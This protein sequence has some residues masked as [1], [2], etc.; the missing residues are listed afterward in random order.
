MGDDVYK[1]PLCV[2]TWDEQEVFSLGAEYETS[3]GFFITQYD[4]RDP[5]HSWLP[6]M[7]RGDEGPWLLPEML[8]V[9]TW[10]DNVRTR[11]SGEHWDRLR[12]YCYK[13]AGHR[14]EICGNKGSPAI[15][16]HEVWVFDDKTRTQRLQRLIALCVKCHKAHHLGF[17]RKLGIYDDV[18]AHMRWV[19]DW[20]DTR[21]KAALAGA[22]RTFEKRSRERWSVDISWVYSP[23]GY[24]YV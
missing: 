15:E 23:Q 1:I 12:R 3:F 17:A 22:Q 7:H 9:T 11:V 14:C 21:L 10:E 18:L 19:N 5:F 20:D 13:A 16:A 8:P 6:V 2:P 4:F 24:R